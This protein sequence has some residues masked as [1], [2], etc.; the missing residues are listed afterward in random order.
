MPAARSPTPTDVA[1]VV[2]HYMCG[3]QNTAGRIQNGQPDIGILSVQAGD[4]GMRY[5]SSEPPGADVGSSLGKD[6]CD[7]RVTLGH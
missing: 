1:P 6:L 5:T 3:L 7:G 4:A 2:R